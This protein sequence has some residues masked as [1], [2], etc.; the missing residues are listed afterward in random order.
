MHSILARATKYALGFAVVL[1]SLTGS[2][3]L[4]QAGAKASCTVQAADYLGGKAEELA[5][6]WGKLGIF[7][8][9]P[10][11]IWTTSAETRIGP[12]PGGSRTSSTGRAQAESPWTIRPFRFRCCRTA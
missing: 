10:G 5:H 1:G 7:P 2:T 6:Q 9:P 11:S 8:K 12:C 3:L 4:G